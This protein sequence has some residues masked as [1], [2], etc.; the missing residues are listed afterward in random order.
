MSMDKVKFRR[1]VLPGDQLRIEV[2]V[3]KLRSKVGQAY[4]RAMVE[5]KVAAEAIF[6]FSLGE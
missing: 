5:N 2:S 4:G 6:M 3:L 1:M